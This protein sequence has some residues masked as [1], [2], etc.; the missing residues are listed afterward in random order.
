M[1]TSVED[2]KRYQAELKAKAEASFI[3]SAYWPIWKHMSNYHG[4]TLLDSECESILR[5]ADQMLMRNR[6]C[7]DCGCS[8]TPKRYEVV[9]D[10]RRR[11]DFQFLYDRLSHLLYIWDHPDSV[12]AGFGP[13][14]TMALLADELPKMKSKY[15]LTDCYE[16][17]PPNASAAHPS[18]EL[19][20]SAAYARQLERRLSELAASL[21]RCA[22]AWNTN[23]AVPY[24]AWKTM[25]QMAD[26]AA[27]IAKIEAG[28]WA[29]VA[30]S[31]RER[32]DAADKTQQPET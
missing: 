3:T 29:S 31:A 28:D 7:E 9:D 21:D 1:I 5:V 11:Q 30:D 18:P 24:A 27:L 12:Q 6:M 8:L 32:T 16:R 14:E 17:Q 2:M 26:H 4:L 19:E 23:E 10:K 15:K 13:S 20:K 22:N 25:R